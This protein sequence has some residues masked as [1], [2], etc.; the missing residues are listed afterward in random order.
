MHE[1]FQLELL[2]E[3]MVDP[4]PFIMFEKWYNQ[5]IEAKV[6][7]PTAMTLTTS[8]PHGFPSARIVLLKGFSETGFLFFSNYNSRKGREMDKNPNVALLFH[9]PELK[10][11]IRIEGFAIKSTDDVSDEY[12]DSRSYES[13]ISAIVSAQSQPIP[14]RRYLEDLWNKKQEE[15]S[16]SKIKRPDFWGGYITVPRRIEFWQFRENRLHDRVIYQHE[17]E[18]WKISRLAP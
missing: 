15:L 11:Q 14:G 13:R 6:N 16:G 10:R 18:K 9:W 17:E 12:F 5:A 2:D 4:D 7:E 3:M 8:T 1:I